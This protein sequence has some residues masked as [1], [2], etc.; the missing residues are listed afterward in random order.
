MK[1]N[2]MVA[3]VTGSNKGIGKAIADRFE[4]EG[5]IVIRNGT[6]ES[7]YTNYI[8]ADVSKKSEVVRIKKYIN[9]NYNKLDI[10]VN[11]AAFTKFIP[12]HDLDALTDDIINRIFNVNVKGSIF[13]TQIFKEIL[14]KSPSGLI[15]NIASIAG[16]TG[17]GSNIAYCA[18]KAA[19][20]NLTKSLAICL[21]PVR[22]NSI[23]P[24]LIETGFVKFPEG[25]IPTT[26]EKTPLKRIGKPEDIADVAWSLLQSNFITGE[27]VLVDGGLIL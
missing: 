16:I 13:C 24:G 3:L 2:K 18:S 20:I 19:L 25:H 6:S 8:K 10:L 26:I 17:K 21:A 7:N 5:I 9:K 4:N 23:S 27:N 11:N 15:I 14:M 22:V 12:Y 1:K